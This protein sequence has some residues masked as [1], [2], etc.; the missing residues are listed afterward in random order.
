MRIALSEAGQPATATGPMRRALA[1]ARHRD[2]AD[3][4]TRAGVLLLLLLP[5][6]G[7]VL[8]LGLGAV[9]VVTARLID[10]VL[11]Y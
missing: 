6:L 5:S 11:A 9:V 8:A 3:E 10:A 7:A 1:Y 2:V 4:R